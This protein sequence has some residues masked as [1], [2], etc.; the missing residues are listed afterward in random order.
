MLASLLIFLVFLI[1][2]V[3]VAIFLGP[4]IVDQLTGFLDNVPS[5]IELLEG[6]AKDLVE[7]PVGSALGLEPAEGESPLVAALGDGAGIL[8]GVVEGLLRSISSIS[9]RWTW[10]FSIMAIPG[11]RR[12]LA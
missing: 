4:V 6:W 1:A 3:G 10:L 7:G 5:Y 2:V 9:S 12:P 8:A 11:Q